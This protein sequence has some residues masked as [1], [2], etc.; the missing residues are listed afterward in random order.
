M[1]Q[2]ESVPDCDDENDTSVEFENTQTV[3]KQE[4]SNKKEETDNLPNVAY[5]DNLG[6]Y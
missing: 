3:I 5:A 6:A 1:T 4:S 2:E